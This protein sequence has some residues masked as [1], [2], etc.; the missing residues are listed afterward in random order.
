MSPSGPLLSSNFL[1]SSS[2]N[3]KTSVNFFSVWMTS[4]SLRMLGCWSSLSRAISLIA[5]LGIP[6]ST[7]SSLIFLSAMISPVLRSTLREY[8]LPCRRLH[9][10]LPLCVQFFGIFQAWISYMLTNNNYNYILYW[11]ISFMWRMLIY[12]SIVSWDKFNYLISYDAIA[13]L[14]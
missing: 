1:R 7:D 2:R 11:A 12:Y 9:M 3:S 13:S 4:C 8:L 10:F 6:S 5:V 14:V